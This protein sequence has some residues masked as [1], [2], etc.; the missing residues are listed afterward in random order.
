ME[1]WQNEDSVSQVP[2]GE[3][4]RM[5]H[6]QDGNVRTPLSSAF[7]NCQNL[8]YVLREIGR[9]TG[10]QLN[11]KNIVVVPNLELFIYLEETVRV[12]AY[13]ENSP[14]ALSQ[15]NEMVITHEVGE[16]YRGLRRRELF[17]KWF[18]FKDRPRVISRPEDTFG[19]HRY[20]RLDTGAYGLSSPDRSCWAK[21]QAEQ[22][23]RACTDFTPDLFKRFYL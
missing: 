20:E 17:F 10:E 5:Y 8:Q 21:F 9:R 11:R 22:Q 13:A 4:D 3:Y 2:I 15:L 18:W 16:Q 14:R 7:F 1:I 6:V 19:R 12:Y 23:A